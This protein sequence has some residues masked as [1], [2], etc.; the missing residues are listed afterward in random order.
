MQGKQIKDGATVR[1]KVV[2]IF[3]DEQSSPTDRKTKGENG[4]KRN[5]HNPDVNKPKKPTIA[6]VIVI[7]SQIQTTVTNLQI[8][9]NNLETKVNNLE[10]KVTNL[11]NEIRES[12]KRIMKQVD[13]K[14][15][16][17]DEKIDKIVRLNNLKTE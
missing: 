11:E 3:K 15:D 2:D 14:I 6:D 1:C 10:T 9:V 7:L 12:E 8:T 17:L 4:T 5:P 16:K 13:E